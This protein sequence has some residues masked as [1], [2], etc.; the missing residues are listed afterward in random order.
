MTTIQPRHIR[1]FVCRKG[2]KTSSQRLALENLWPRYGLSVDVPFNQD[3]IFGRSAPTVL[4]IGF[5]DGKSLATMAANAPEK[6]FIGIEVYENGIGRLL[7]SLEKMHLSNVRI[8]HHDAI[9]VLTK[10]I[11]DSSLETIQIFFADPWPK[12]RH[13]KRRLIQT[14]FI[15]LVAKK[16]KKGGILHLATDW[17]DY[18]YQMMSVL[19]ASD[20]FQNL[21]GEGQFAPR[22]IFR[23]LTK[24]EQRGLKLGH[25]TWDLLFEKEEKC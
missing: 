20:Y 15:D 25:N 3:A 24:Y 19:S 6:D 12:S 4:E 22:P 11:P 18:A 14:T 2:K 23:P 7:A 10:C 5:G 17:M 13:H 1:S 16:L 9:E 8:F 21:A